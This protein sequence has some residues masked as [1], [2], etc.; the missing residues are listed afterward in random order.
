MLESGPS[1]GQI[2]KE[3]WI[4]SDMMNETAQFNMPALIPNG[5]EGMLQRARKEHLVVPLSGYRVHVQ[6]AAPA[7]ISPYAWN[8]LKSFWTLYFREAGAELVSYSAEALAD[9]GE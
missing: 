5:A 1:S 4:F 9:R 7:G 8:S 3:I 6:R 2:T